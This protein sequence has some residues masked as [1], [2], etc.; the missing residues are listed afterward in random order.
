MYSSRAGRDPAARCQGYQ[1]SSYSVLTYRAGKCPANYDGGSWTCFIRADGAQSAGQAKRR[2]RHC[3]CWRAEGRRGTSLQCPHRR[4][5]SFDDLLSLS[6]PRSWAWIL[7]TILKSSTSY[8]G[9]APQ[10]HVPQAQRRRCGYPTDYLRSVTTPSASHMSRRHLPGNFGLPL[11]M[12]YAMR[13]RSR[14]STTYSY[15]VS[16]KLPGTYRGRTP[17]SEP[18]SSSRARGGGTLGG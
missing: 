6:P 7:H 12:M 10:V 17:S 16:C 14:H 15:I 2:Y 8:Q 5:L 1:I 18:R 3:G 4:L 13:R 11:V 9:S